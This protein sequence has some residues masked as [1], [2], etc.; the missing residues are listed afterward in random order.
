MLNRGYN[1]DL[2]MMALHELAE[3]YGASYKLDPKVNVRHFTSRDALPEEMG[4][5]PLFE[6][7]DDLSAFNLGRIF[8]PDVK[9]EHLEA[10]GWRAVKKLTTITPKGK[11]VEITADPATYPVFAQECHYADDN[12]NEQLFY[13]IYEPFS[14]NKDYRFWTIGNVPHDYMFGRDALM[15]YWRKGGEKTLPVVLVVSFELWLSVYMVQ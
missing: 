7:F 12:G 4:M 1:D 9:A 10:Y 14:F 2:F 5:Q 11:F 6:F 3:Q 13:K 8:T 15:R